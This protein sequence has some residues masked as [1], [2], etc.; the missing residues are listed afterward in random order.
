MKHL[1]EF[2]ASV[3]C[4]T[5]RNR[6]L[7]EPER[8]RRMTVE[9]REPFPLK[10]DHSGWDTLS[11][12]EIISN[13]Q[14]EQVGL[15][16]EQIAGLFRVKALYRQGAYHEATPEHKRLSA[17]CTCRVAWKANPWSQRLCEGVQ[18]SE[19]TTSYARKERLIK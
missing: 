16:S 5:A 6:W 15:S 7:Q 1:F 9:F 8:H 11:R 12:E 18:G 19:L 17:G 10:M 3:G 14:L 2:D 13:R 4:R